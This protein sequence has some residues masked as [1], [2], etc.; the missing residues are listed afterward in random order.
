MPAE[1]NESPDYR[2]EARDYTDELAELGMFYDIEVDGVVPEVP[3]GGVNDID[4]D[5]FELREN[6][7]LDDALAGFAEMAANHG[8]YRR[9][10]LYGD[11]CNHLSEIQA[12]KDRAAELVRYGVTGAAEITGVAEEMGQARLAARTVDTCTNACSDPRLEELR[13]IAT[14]PANIDLLQHEAIIRGKEARPIP[15]TGEHEALAELIDAAALDTYFSY[16]SA[17]G[18]APQVIRE[19]PGSCAQVTYTLQQ[20]LFALGLSAEVQMYSGHGQSMFSHFSLRVGTGTC[21][22]LR[23]CPTWQQFLPEGTAHDGLP[24][25]L[26]APERQITEA[27]ARLGV[28]PE[29]QRVWEASKPTTIDWWKLK[30]DSLDCIMEADGWSDGPLSMPD[31][32]A[33]AL[34]A[35]REQG[36]HL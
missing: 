10:D 35:A 14:N 9:Y 31:H 11:V 16:S 3:E 30:A 32:V 6:A 23:A 8:R 24:H 33:A 1:F 15:L 12:Y 17:S 19:F 20:R 13:R 4:D 26:I 7:A 21:E 2:N 27:A 28:P 18:K 25:T 36:R 5:D 29:W 34:E 22:P